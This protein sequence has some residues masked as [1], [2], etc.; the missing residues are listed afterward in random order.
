MRTSDTACF[1][2]N[3]VSSKTVFPPGSLS[4]SFCFPNLLLD[5]AARI[6]T[7]KF[8][9]MSVF[10][11]GLVTNVEWS[12]K[13]DPTNTLFGEIYYVFLLVDGFFLFFRGVRDL[14]SNLW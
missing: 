6:I 11:N 12:E 8:V 7:L 3:I 9:I 5:P 4:Q 10:L 14:L 2:R 1:T 13:I